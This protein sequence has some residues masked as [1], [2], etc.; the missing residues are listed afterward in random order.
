MLEEK[1]VS[2]LSIDFSFLQSGNYRNYRSALRSS[3]P[4]CMPYLAVYFRDLTFIGI[5]FFCFLKR[6]ISL[7]YLFKADGNP[8]YLDEEKTILN[9]ERIRMEA[10]ILKDIQSFQEHEFLFV[11][12]DP[13]QVPIHIYFPL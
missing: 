12:S 9:F 4:P 11:P 5:I 3:D 10:V 13:I 7:N 2:S 1:F 6:F 8:K